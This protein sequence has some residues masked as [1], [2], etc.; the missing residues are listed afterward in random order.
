MSAALHPPPRPAPD[1]AAL[2]GTV[3]TVER[4]ARR[5]PDA[6]ALAFLVVNDTRQVVAYDMAVLLRGGGRRWRVAAISGLV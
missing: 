1:L 6:G 2:L 4:E 3:L 5:M